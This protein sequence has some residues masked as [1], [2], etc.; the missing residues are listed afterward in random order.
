MLDASISILPNP[1]LTADGFSVCIMFYEQ[2]ALIP[3]NN[4]EV[5]KERQNGVTWAAIS[6]LLYWCILPH[7]TSAIKSPDPPDLSGINIWCAV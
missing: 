3:S 1:L 6:C 5:H 7:G 2:T 4:R